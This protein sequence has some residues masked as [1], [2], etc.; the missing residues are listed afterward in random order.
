MTTCPG[1]TRL[2]EV[3]LPSKTEKEVDFPPSNT[4]SEESKTTEGKV[5]V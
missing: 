4:W 1:I 3:T 2:A 5:G